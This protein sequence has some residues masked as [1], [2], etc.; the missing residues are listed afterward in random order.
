MR[1]KSEAVLTFA[2]KQRPPAEE[3]TG[4]SGEVQGDQSGTAHPEILDAVLDDLKRLPHKGNMRRQGRQRV[5]VKH[6]DLTKNSVSQ[7]RRRN[8]FRKNR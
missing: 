2:R 8:D 3:R 1:R 4:L 6:T 7:K 5:H